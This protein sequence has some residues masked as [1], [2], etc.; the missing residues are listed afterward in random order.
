MDLMMFGIRFRALWGLGDLLFSI[1]FC[2][3]RII[4][5][6]ERKICHEKMLRE[7]R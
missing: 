1:S 7:L 5:T 3:R 4:M 6:N 2:I